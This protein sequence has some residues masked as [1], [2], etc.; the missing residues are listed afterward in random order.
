M[1]RRPPRS[2]LSSSSAASDVYKRQ[3]LDK[4][5]SRAFKYR[6][7]AQASSSDED[8]NENG[9]DGGAIHSIVSRSNYNFSSKA[10][11]TGTAIS[12][13]KASAVSKRSK[14]RS[15]AKQIIKGCL[16][17]TSPSPRDS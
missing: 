17:Y 14:A 15:V 8:N 12:T 11:M 2:T 5:L 4:E 9:D 7:K 10:S 1:I 6:T 16:L 13:G 3:P